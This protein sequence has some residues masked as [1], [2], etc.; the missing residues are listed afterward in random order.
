[1]LIGYQ[2]VHLAN[3]FGMANGI[4]G[5][6]A[7]VS[8][9]ALKGSLV[10]MMAA[11]CAA[12]MVGSLSLNVWLLGWQRPWIRPLPR[13]FALGTVRTLFGQGILFFV[14]QL[15]GLVIFNSDNLV[16]SHFLGA[17]EVTP[18]SIAWRMTSYAVLLQQLTVPSLWPV[19]TEAYGK[20]QI[21]WVRS[22]YE[23]T[24]RRVLGAVSGAALLVGLFGRLV[25]RLWAGAAAVPRAELLWLMAGFAVLQATTTN[26]AVL[27]TATGRLRLEAIVGALAAIMNLWLSIVLVQRIGS[28]GVILATILSFLVFMVVPQEWEVRRVLEGRY[29][30]TRRPEMPSE[31]H[32]EVPVL[33]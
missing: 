31:L 9:V 27:L 28:V 1:M 13:C 25:I 3:Y 17:A 21:D 12:T 2:Q 10:T 19:F 15:T 8:T 6:L 14:L 4:G 18:Y 22:T 30:P 7:I 23:A 24:T 16:I 26:Q 33:S 29:L 32:V 11:Y 20:G 5:L